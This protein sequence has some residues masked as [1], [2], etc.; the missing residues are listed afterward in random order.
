MFRL[1]PPR[2]ITTILSALVCLAL[3]ALSS[4][5]ADGPASRADK[6][7]IVL[8][9]DSTVTDATGWGV[10][11]KA[12]LSD[13]VQC[14]NLA[15]GGR[16]S[17]SF[18]AEGLW[19]KALDLK[20]DY[21]LIQFGHN[22]SPGH[23]ATRETDPNTTYRA[24]MERYVDEARAAGIQP[25]LVTSLSRRQWGSDGKIHSTLVPYVEVVKQIASAKKIP[26]IDLHAR[27]I[28]LY[29]QMGK[30]AV[31]KISPLKNA[32]PTT[33]G[34]DTPTP[35]SSGFDGTHLNAAGSKLIGAM[36]AA[37]LA[38]AVPALAPVI[39]VADSR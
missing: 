33:E 17:R 19:Q 27:S 16:S 20:P 37:E 26:L 5:A 14:I 3:F 35:R 15:R 28:E 39:K 1:A 24:N 29:K 34:S 25:V 7:R 32:E 11:F 6:V 36:V 10:G 38:K 13:G 8:V 18:L 21:V 22:D 9:G 4:G 30:E 23:G 12:C 2:Q 31:Q